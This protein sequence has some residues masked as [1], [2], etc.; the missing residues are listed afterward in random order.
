FV[1]VND[2]NAVS[3]SQKAFS[4][5]KTQAAIGTGDKDVARLSTRHGTFVPS[6]GF[7]RCNAIGET[8]VSI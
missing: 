7:Y 5:R 1:A 2:P 3:Q 6:Y 4:H 8:H